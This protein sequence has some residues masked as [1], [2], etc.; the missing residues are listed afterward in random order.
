M[1]LLAA[2]PGPLQW[3]VTH[4]SFDMVGPLRT[5]RSPAAERMRAHR[6]RKKSGMRCVMLELRETEISALV[7]KGFLKPDARND[8]SQ[9]TDA[10]YAYF[11]CELT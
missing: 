10:L 3:R 7:E 6:E 5:G 2:V 8:T 9:I 4:T 11:D 1:S